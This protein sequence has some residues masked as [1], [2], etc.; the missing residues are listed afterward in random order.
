MSQIQVSNCT[1]SYDGSYDLIFDNVSFILDSDWKLGFCGRNGRGKTT[2]LKLLMNKYEYKGTINATVNFEYFP[3][4]VR[5]ETDLTINNIE[6]NFEYWQLQKELSLLSVSEDVLYRPFNTLSNGEK[7]KILLVSLFL[8]ENSFLLIDEPTNHLDKEARKLVAEYLNKKSGFILVSH[9]RTFLDACVDHILSI[10]KTNIEINQGNFSSWYYNKNLQDNYEQNENKRLKKD[11]KRLTETSKEKA[12][13]SFK[14]EDTKI[15][16]G[17]CDRGFI[18]AQAARMMKRS[19]SIEKRYLKQID[20][21]NKLLKNIETTDKLKLSPLMYHSKRLVSVENLSINY[22][23]IPVFTNLS[24]EILQGELVALNGKNGCGKSS[25]IQLICGKNICYQGTFIK[26][27]D[28]KI[29]YVYQ[30]TSN[31]SGTIIEYE[32]LHDLDSSL[33]RAIL[34]KLDFSRDQFDKKLENYSQGQK[35]KVLIAHSLCEKAHLYIW[36]EPLNYIDIFSRIQIEELIK[37]YKP[38]M[39]IV[40]HDESFIH[41]INAKIIDF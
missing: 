28:L 9:D 18:G 11:I 6:G 32:K 13:W 7:T 15:G 26:A 31:L 21:K 14:V 35:K 30:D 20:E 41:N 38:T 40:E 2:F 23:G 39:L 5:D 25:V 34:R 27:N 36:D 29:S 33:F 10:N 16:N 3:Y 22:D 12:A 19:K 1:F 17:P 24:F 4:E 37:E 8:R